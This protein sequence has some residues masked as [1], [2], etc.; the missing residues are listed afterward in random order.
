MVIVR[1][2]KVRVLVSLSLKDGFLEWVDKYAILD[3]R[4]S[5]SSH[6][7]GT[8]TLKEINLILRLEDPDR[9]RICHL[10]RIQ[11]SDKETILNVRSGLVIVA[12]QNDVDHVSS[13]LICHLEVVL[14]QIDCKSVCVDIAK[15][16]S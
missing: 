6:V 3:V 10:E 16:V 4:L 12:S 2:H 11:V 5:I 1:R 15:L 7:L 14:H 13:K 8:L 9:G